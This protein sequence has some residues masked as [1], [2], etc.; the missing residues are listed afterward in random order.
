[1]DS[2]HDDS[3]PW[4]ATEAG[5]TYHPGQDAGIDAAFSAFERV[6]SGTIAASKEPSSEFKSLKQVLVKSIGPYD[7]DEERKR[8]LERFAAA[9]FYN[10]LYENLQ[11]KYYHMSLKSCEEDLQKYS[12]RTQGGQLSLSPWEYVHYWK[13][14]MIRMMVL[15]FANC[16]RNTIRTID[17]ILPEDRNQ[18]L[19]TL[20]GDKTP[21]VFLKPLLFS[22]IV[23]A[24]R[25]RNL[26]I[27][28]RKKRYHPEVVEMKE[29]IDMEIA[30]FLP[31][32]WDLFKM[33]C[34]ALYPEDFP[35]E[36]NGENQ[37]LNVSG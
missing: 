19:Q 16:I 12:A 3:S 22:F 26:V 5:I 23:G 21:E 24:E 15:P 34:K 20:Y 14:S 33:R 37:A 35:G 32:N 36:E 6:H 7:V 29:K 27:S 9:M 18:I 17:S 31:V 8:G 2:R 30:G 11:S 1:M 28:R 4:P 25:E 10:L 13:L